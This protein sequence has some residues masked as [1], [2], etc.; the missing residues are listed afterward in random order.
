ML[1]FTSIVFICH[2]CFQT[3]PIGYLPTNLVHLGQYLIISGDKIPPCGVPF[4]GIPS[5]SISAFNSFDMMESN[6]LSL[7]PNDQICF[8]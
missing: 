2:N 4:V 6:D 1:V 8:K 3:F 7:M 5:P